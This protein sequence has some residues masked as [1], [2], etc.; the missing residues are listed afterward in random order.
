IRPLAWLALPGIAVGFFWFLD[1]R[2]E[3]N[4]DW[5]RLEAAHFLAKVFPQV[6]DS[7]S[8]I[9][10]GYAPLGKVLEQHQSFREEPDIK[11]A[12][13]AIEKP[14]A[15]MEAMHRQLQGMWRY[16]SREVRKAIEVGTA[17][18]ADRIR[19]YRE[20]LRCL[21]A[22]KDWTRAEE[23]EISATWE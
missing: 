11:K 21:D 17:Y 1:S 23:K 3:T 5:A 19:Y 22:G 7:V 6:Q 15:D 13:E 10:K 12:R 2:R 9:Q 18:L 8:D 16:R 4:A 20:A 14:L